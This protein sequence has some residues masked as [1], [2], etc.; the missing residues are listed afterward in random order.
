[1][2]LFWGFIFALTVFTA[3]LL[4]GRR[5]GGARGAMRDASPAESAARTAERPGIADAVGAADAADA[6]APGVEQAAE[7]S[8]ATGPEATLASERG[9]GADDNASIAAIPG[10]ARDPGAARSEADLVVAI[11]EP[12]VIE[13]GDVPAAAEMGGADGG[14]VLVHGP[15][16]R[17]WVDDPGEVSDVLNSL[18]GLDAAEVAAANAAPA[19]KDGGGP[20]VMSAEEAAA[21]AERYKVPGSGTRED[22]FVVDWRVLSSARETYNPRKGKTQIPAWVSS[23]DGKVV[24]L[25]GFVLLPVMQTTTQEIL[26]MA[27]EWDGCCIGVP[28]TPYDAVEVKLNAPTKK[29]SAAGFSYGRVTGV[30]KV[31]PYLVKDWLVG[32]YVMEGAEL[33]DVGF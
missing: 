7:A 30:L 4:A 28:P 29:L 6:A 17:A 15:S 18:L 23:L 19:V 14:A 31:D 11:P 21:A 10:T 33:G 2:K 5:G 3:G 27:N 8:V 9:S 16:G 20:A 24:E 32:L 1:M 25:N 22:P 26:V 13:P 12:I